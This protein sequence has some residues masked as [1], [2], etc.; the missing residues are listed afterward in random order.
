MVGSVG[1]GLVFAKRKIHT[2]KKH[3]DETKKE[4]NYILV[5]TNKPRALHHTYDTSTP[6]FWYVVQKKNLWYAKKNLV[7]KQIFI[8]EKRA[9]WLGGKGRSVVIEKLGMLFVEC[10]PTRCHAEGLL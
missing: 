6:T 8:V 7:S 2:K 4:S 1:F 9:A 3:S 10:C 5:S